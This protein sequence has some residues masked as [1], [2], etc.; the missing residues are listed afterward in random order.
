MPDRLAKLREDGVFCD[1]ILQSGTKQLFAHRIIL[2]AVSDYFSLLFKYEGGF[3]K[4]AINFDEN[5]I[6]GDSLENIINY[7]YTGQIDITI[8]N[9][10]DLLVAADYFDIKFIR[11]KCEEL[12]A[13]MQKSEEY[14]ISYENLFNFIW[15]AAHFNLSSLL[16]SICAFI[17]EHFM[18]ESMGKILMS[19]S[20]HCLLT[21]L[22]EEDF[23][24]INTGIPADNVDLELLKFI[25]QYI[26]E[27]DLTDITI[28]TVTWT[29]SA[30]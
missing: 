10:Y 16:K 14:F 27:H 9:V 29:H 22:R 1:V 4:P 12:L 11:E 8:E 2:I 15:F 7:A 28:F 21:L 24:V 25:S 30:V 19:L 5:L 20:P 23:T 26:N 18:E 3:Q 6:N 17:S 13:D